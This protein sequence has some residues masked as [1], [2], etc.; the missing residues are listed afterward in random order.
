MFIHD[1]GT[2]GGSRNPGGNQYHPNGSKGGKFPR[3]GK[4]WQETERGGPIRLVTQPFS[5][6]VYGFIKW[7]VE[8]IKAGRLR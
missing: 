8:V 1:H 5:R 3:S 2:E 4:G 7:Q 6:Y